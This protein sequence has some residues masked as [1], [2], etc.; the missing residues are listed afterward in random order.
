MVLDP[1]QT[2]VAYRCP[3][4]GAGVMSVVGLFSLTA[5]M[6]KLKCTCGQSE[7]SIVYSKDGKVRLN[8]PCILCPNPH[9]FT[10]NSSVFFNNDLF[11]LPCPY[12]DINICMTGEQNKVKAELARTELELLDM[13]QENGLDNFDIF[14]GEQTLTDPQIL[15]I[16]L[17][18]INDLDAE[19]KIYCKC[20]TDP[21]AEGAEGN[22]EVEMTPEG[23]KVSCKNC[24]A[25]KTIPSNSLINA[26]EFLNCDSLTLE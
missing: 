7:M 4:C 9:S 11:L 2:T 23:I 22:Y 3:H 24:G 1:K 20:K 16:I 17:F 26:H 6:I 8:V 21:S 12:S 25:Q 5:D 15:D 18:V 14:H 19:G 10:V 13:L